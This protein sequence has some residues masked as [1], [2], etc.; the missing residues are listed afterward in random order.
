[1]FRPIDIENNNDLG[2]TNKYNSS[3][4][5]NQLS[6]PT[7]TDEKELFE[8]LNDMEHGFESGENL[9]ESDRDSIISYDKVVGTKLDFEGENRPQPAPRPRSLQ[10]KEDS[11]QPPQIPARRPG[12]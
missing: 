10:I 6:S 9:S 12:S 4:V 3:P 8:A 1:M 11:L 7:G 5:I 2:N